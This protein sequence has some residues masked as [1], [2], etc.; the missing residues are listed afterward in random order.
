MLFEYRKMGEILQG[1]GLKMAE[2]AIVVRRGRSDLA[3]HPVEGEDLVIGRA[4]ECDV[5]LSDSLVSR[6]H[7]RIWLEND[8]LRLEDLHSRNGV[9]VNGARVQTCCLEEND[10]IIIGGHAL[11]VIRT[12]LDKSLAEETST[13]TFDDA[14]RLY[15]EMVGAEGLGRL[16]ILY[17]ATKLLATVFDIDTLFPQLLDL[18]LEAVPA[19]RGFVLTLCPETRQPV[20][21]ASRPPTGPGVPLSQTLVRHVLASK[22]AIWTRNAQVDERIPLSDSIVYH[23]IRA[24]MC[25]PLYGRD[26]VVGAIY[27]DSGKEDSEFTNADLELLTAIGRVAGVAAENAQ[28][29]QEKLNHERLAAIGQA[30]AGIGHC[31]KNVLVGIKGGGEFIDLGVERVDLEWVKKGWPVVRRSLDRMERLVLNLLNLSRDAEPVLQPVQLEQLVTEVFDSVRPYADQRQVAFEF[32]QGEVGPVYLDSQDIF[33]VILNLVVN[34]IES[35]ERTGGTVKVSTRRDAAG[36]YIE[37]S[38]T[39]SGIPQAIRD[40][41]FQAFVTTKGSRGTGLGLACCEKLVRAHHGK[42][43]VESAPSHGSSPCSFLTAPF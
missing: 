31:V 40:R 27:V 14:S 39:G 20:I 38:D 41:L 29:H 3:T 32:E 26:A 34:A 1:G 37:V 33:R 16:P 10:E 12:G 35:C 2:Y 13:I 36:C 15:E 23:N 17:K 28:L 6:K 25:V 8:G 43:T 9:F 21:R 30:A 22:N 7:A 11:L 18:I 5:V 42:I 24:A 4:S 19:R